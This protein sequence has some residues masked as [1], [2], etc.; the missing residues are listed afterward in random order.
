MSPRS[1]APPSVLIVDDAARIR[2]VLVEFL[3]DDG[4]TVHA[5]AHGQAALDYLHTHPA[6]CCIM[7]DLYMPVMDGWQFHRAQLRSP[8]LAHIPV[9]V[10]SAVARALQ[11]LAWFQAAG[12]L[13]KPFGVDAV[14]ALVTPLCAPPR[15]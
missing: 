6:P 11:P 4:Y 12:Y 10:M 7:L 14:L 13:P 8:A 5:V 15:P 9:I 1:V 3:E 2:E